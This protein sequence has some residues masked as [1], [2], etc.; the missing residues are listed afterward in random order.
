MELENMKNDLAD[1]QQRKKE[2][3]EA[4][5]LHLI[6]EAQKRQQRDWYVPEKDNDLDEEFAKHVNNSSYNVHVQ[7]LKDGQYLYG[8]KRVYAKIMNGKLVV[9][10]NG[11]FMLI[12]EFL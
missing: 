5:K 8:T 10:L 2:E 6:E 11:G 12:E 4:F 7:R 1:V 9:R 3:E